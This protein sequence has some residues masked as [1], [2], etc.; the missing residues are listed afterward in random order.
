MAVLHL[1]VHL[2]RK[3]SLPQS[4][5]YVKTVSDKVVRLTYLPFAGLS[6]RAKVIGGGRSLKCLLCD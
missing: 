2:I 4:F 5:F 6:N 3:G 1:K